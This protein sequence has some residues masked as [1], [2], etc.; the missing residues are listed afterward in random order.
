[1]LIAAASFSC[2]ASRVTLTGQAPSR[3]SLPSAS[4]SLW[5][6]PLGEAAKT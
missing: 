3:D 4:E 2:V 6:S 1:M 5:I